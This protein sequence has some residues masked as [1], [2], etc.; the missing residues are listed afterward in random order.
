MRRYRDTYLAGA[1]GG[2]AD[3]EAYYRLAPQVLESIPGDT[4]RQDLLVIY[5]FMIL[6]CAVLAKLGFNRLTRQ[7]YTTWT[8]ALVKR[9]GMQAG[10]ADA[11]G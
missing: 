7:L 2:K 10:L 1:A 5:A 11:A 9:Y 4:R 6:P 8:R 3:I